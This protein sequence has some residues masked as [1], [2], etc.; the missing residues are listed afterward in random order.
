M[1]RGCGASCATRTLLL[2]LDDECGLV[3]DAVGLSDLPQAIVIPQGAIQ[4]RVADFLGR[5]LLVSLEDLFDLLPILL[6]VSA[7]YRICIKEDDVTRTH[8]G[9]LIQ[10]KSSHLNTPEQGGPCGAAAASRLITTP[11][12]GKQNQAVN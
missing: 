6:I 11:A 1:S 12:T 8:Q 9:E 2:S 3:I 10:V 5:P 4:N 7:I